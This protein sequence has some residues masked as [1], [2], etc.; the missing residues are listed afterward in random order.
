MRPTLLEGPC[1][2]SKKLPADNASLYRMTRTEEMSR[3]RR[4][5]LRDIRVGLRSP[6]TSRSL[7]LGSSLVCP[8]I[9]TLLLPRA[10]PFCVVLTRLGRFGVG[11]GDVLDMQIYFLGGAT[12][13]RNR[14]PRFKAKSKKRHM[15]YLKI[16]NTEE[17]K[18]QHPIIRTRL[19]SL[20]AEAYPEHEDFSVMLALGDPQC[21][22]VWTDESSVGLVVKAALAPIAKLPTSVLCPSRRAG[23]CTATGDWRE[24]CVYALAQGYGSLGRL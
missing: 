2:A 1:T 22:P 20:N 10:V 21:S 11:C 13:S 6:P 5:S 7:I 12:F 8:A 14:I 19:P 4:L 16:E 9:S 24:S 15:A 17:K 3:R 23:S 18:A